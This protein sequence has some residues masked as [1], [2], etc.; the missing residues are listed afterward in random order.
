MRWIVLWTLLGSLQA[1][2]R[3]WFRQPAKNWFEALPV[4]NGRL[5]AMVFGGAPEERL[6]LN[7]D[8]VWAGKRMDRI[9]PE[10]RAAVAKSRA[11]LAEGKLKEA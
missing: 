9:N 1:D 7:E 5:G 6:Q 10:G 11:L 2:D 3:I 4:G 8:T